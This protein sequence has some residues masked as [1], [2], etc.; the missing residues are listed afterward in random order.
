MGVREGAVV[1]VVERA[2][3]YVMMGTKIIWHFLLLLL[4][5]CR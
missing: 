3:D 4:F 5:L 2:F 1:V